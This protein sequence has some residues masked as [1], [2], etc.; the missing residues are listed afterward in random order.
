MKKDRVWSAEDQE[1]LEAFDEDQRI[2]D[3]REE[4]H[5]SRFMKN[6]DL[7]S[8]RSSFG[9]DGDKDDDKGSISL[10][11]TLAYGKWLRDQADESE[12]TQNRQ[13]VTDAIIAAVDEFIA[14]GTKD[15]QE[16]FLS[17]Y[18]E[19]KQQVEVAA[20]M[21]RLPPSI[22][23]TLKRIQGNLKAYLIKNY[24]ELLKEYLSGLR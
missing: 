20:D 12:Y 23:R 14:S 15:N 7:E 9:E 8:K 19:M 24:P 6:G 2:R 18:G 5:R 3:Q 17:V 22:N 13:Q 11:D 1:K 10:E 16:I 4:A 21:D